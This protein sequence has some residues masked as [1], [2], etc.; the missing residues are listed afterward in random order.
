MGVNEG[1]KITRREVAILFGDVV[2]YSR[3]MDRDEERTFQRLRDCLSQHWQPLLQTYGGRLVGTGG[4]SMFAEFAEAQSA[5]ECAMAIQTRMREVNL[6]LVDGERLVLRIGV[7]FG[8][9]LDSGNDL[10]G[11]VVNVAARLQ[12]V[13]EP[14]GILVSDTV[15]RQLPADLCRQFASAG[16]QRLKNIAEPVLVHRW[17][18]GALVPHRVAGVFWRLRLLARN[19]AG[20]LTVLRRRLTARAPSDTQ[21]PEDFQ[22]AMAVPGVIVLPFSITGD[23]ARDQTL[24]DGMTDEVITILGQQ[25]NLR[26]LARG[27]SFAHRGIGT[28]EARRQLG[29]GYVLEGTVR[30]GTD[31]FSC[32]VRLL[33][34]ATEQVLWT[35][36]FKRPVREVFRVQREIAER[37]AFAIQS[38]VVREEAFRLRSRPPENL[39]AWQLVVQ[40]NHELFARMNSTSL[41]KAEDLLRRAV[42]IDPDYADAWAL[43]AFT[44]AGKVAGGYSLQPVADEA[45]AKALADAALEMAPNDAAVLGAVAAA[46]AHLDQGTRGLA[47]INRAL[48]LAPHFVSFHQTKALALAVLGKHKQA[49]PI[50]ERIIEASPRD[51]QIH[52][53][54]FLLAICYASVG[55]SSQARAML[56]RATDLDPTWHQP[57]MFLALSFGV[58]GRLSAA[59][60]KV[61]QARRLEPGL[62]LEGYEYPFTKSPWPLA[63]VMLLLLR[64]LWRDSDKLLAVG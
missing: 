55:K 54:L 5:A 37:V 15:L 7:N 61:V 40:A 9:V 58:Q 64:K 56:Q 17:R 27:D 10:Y 35:D 3:L 12:A 62:T 44:V 16:A 21:A 59:A 45:E 51:L 46:N 14:G 60:E 47:L 53:T 23:D 18:R 22:T 49:I 42:E 11:A 6:A 32:T 8:T 29:V 30:H 25:A 33:D 26:T 38:T 63:K 24:A 20:G 57:H 36:R 52:M 39:V 34:A 48:Q 41:R 19:A 1:V 31:E 50:F 43:L 13:T 2:G 4:D 28:A